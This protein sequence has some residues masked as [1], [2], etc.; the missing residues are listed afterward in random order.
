MQIQNLN[1]CRMIMLFKF[2]KSGIIVFA[3]RESKTMEYIPL[4]GRIFFFL[5]FDTFRLYKNFYQEIINNL[6]NIDFNNNK[7]TFPVECNIERFLIHYRCTLRS[8]EIF[9]E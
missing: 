9:D 8:S 3:Q 5:N 1:L 7:I 2:T 4:Y 6:V